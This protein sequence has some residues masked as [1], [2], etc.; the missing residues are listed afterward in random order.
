[1]KLMA[2]TKH[3][4]KTSWNVFDFIIVIASLIDLG[5]EDVDGLSVLRG[6]RLVS[7]SFRLVTAVEWCAWTQHSTQQVG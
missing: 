5:L 7:Y 1:M 2:M 3:Y 4:F 6:F